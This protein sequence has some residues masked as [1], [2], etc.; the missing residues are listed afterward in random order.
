M[1]GKIAS[2]DDGNTEEERRGRREEGGLGV[3]EEG[4]GDAVTATRAVG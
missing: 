3:R 4:E 2:V 1:H